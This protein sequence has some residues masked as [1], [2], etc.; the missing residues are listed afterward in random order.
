MRAS[1]YIARLR[2][3]ESAPPLVYT[4]GTEHAYY[5]VLQQQILT[6]PA[7]LGQDGTLSL[8]VHAV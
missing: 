1:K 7:A 5:Q 8:V 3:G 6:H 4:N 2:A